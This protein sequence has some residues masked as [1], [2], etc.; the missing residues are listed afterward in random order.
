MLIRAE[1]QL[2]AQGL[3][4]ATA[5]EQRLVAIRRR[6][7][8]DV[9]ANSRLDALLLELDLTEE[10][11]LLGLAYERFFSDLF[12]GKR[13]QFFTPRPLVSLL[14]SLLELQPGERVLDPTCGTRGFLVGAARQG[15]LGPGIE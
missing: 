9:P 14:L 8:D 11:D 7:G 1:H 3:T 4:G 10:I 2:R 6:L 15:A 13:G 5:F 12:K